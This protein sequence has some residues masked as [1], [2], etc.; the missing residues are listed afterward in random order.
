MR[1]TARGF[2]LIEA[3]VALMLAAGVL[4]GFYKALSTGAVLENRAEDQAAHVLVATSI[5]DRVGAD[6]PLRNGTRENGTTRGL[7][8][9]LTIGDSPTEDMR[10]GVTMPG[11]LLFVFVT[12]GREGPGQVRL[13]TIRY[14]ETPL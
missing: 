6:L 4:G 5:L 14:A 2:S 11:D 3:L 13:R 10:L 12:V 9:T 7:P 1:Q 8:W